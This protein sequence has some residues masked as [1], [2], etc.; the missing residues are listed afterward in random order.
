[1][2]VR[3]AKVAPGSSLS[4]QNVGGQAG[5]GGQ[6]GQPGARGIGGPRG[7]APGLCNSGGRGP[8]A[9]GVGNSFGR[10]LGGGRP[11]LDGQ[12]DVNISGVDSLATGTF[13]KNF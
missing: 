13:S 7:S 10:T 4:I 1:V 11:G 2:I 5:P 12:I 3:F 9:D 6:H 8:G